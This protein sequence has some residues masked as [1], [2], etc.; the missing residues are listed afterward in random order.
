M[1]KHGWGRVC[2]CNIRSFV[3]TEALFLYLYNLIQ[4]F[5]FAELGGVFSC[6]SVNSFNLNDKF[7]LSTI[8]KTHIFKYTE[9]FTPK[10]ENVQIKN[11]GSFRVSAR[12]HRL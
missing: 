8:T 6:K 1:G 7:S 5:E 10:H 11:S 4:T 3:S 9:N 2:L 12:K